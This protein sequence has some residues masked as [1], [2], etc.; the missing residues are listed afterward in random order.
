MREHSGDD[1]SSN[2][3]DQIQHSPPIYQNTSFPFVIRQLSDPENNHTTLV[4]NVMYEQ[5]APNLR[6][7]Q[8][9]HEYQRLPS[10][11]SSSTTSSEAAQSLNNGTPS[12]AAQ[13]TLHSDQSVTRPPLLVRRPSNRTRN[14]PEYDPVYIPHSDATA[15][16]RRLDGSGYVLSSRFRNSPTAF[17]LYED[18]PIFYQL[19]N[20][21]ANSPLQSAMPHVSQ[22]TYSQ[23]PI[24]QYATGFDMAANDSN[25]SLEEQ[26]P[27]LDDEDMLE[28]P[29]EHEALMDHVYSSVNVEAR[30]DRDTVESED[31]MSSDDFTSSDDDSFVPL[32][33]DVNDDIRDQIYET[34]NF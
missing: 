15:M 30:D 13:P 1:G 18:I 26:V 28:E 33:H 8:P 32:Y 20:V 16:E 2:I 27:V 25:F 21:C 14:N 3:Y 5:S 34:V 22:G 17:S 12:H 31:D 19:V 4:D 7:G 11:S 10:E 23:I 6:V 24:Y 9:G 29:G